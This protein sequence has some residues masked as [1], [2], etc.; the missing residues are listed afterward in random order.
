M[1]STT[2]V[3][4]RSRS[5]FIVPQTLLVTTFAQATIDT[6]NAAVDW[7]FPMSVFLAAPTVAMEDMLFPENFIKF[8]WNTSFGFGLTFRATPASRSQASA[9]PPTVTAVD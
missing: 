4:Q 8:I 3:A 6:D 7:C 1:I 9:R 2:K 5:I